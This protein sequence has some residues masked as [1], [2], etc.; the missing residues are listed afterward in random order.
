MNGIANAF[1]IC[2]PLIIFIIFIC[3][4]NAKLLIKKCYNKEKIIYVNTP[5]NHLLGNY[6]EQV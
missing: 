2:V 1:I 4:N 5:N 6:G 3:R